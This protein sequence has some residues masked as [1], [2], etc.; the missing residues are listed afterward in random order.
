M[1]IIVIFPRAAHEAAHNN[2]GGPILQKIWRPG[3][4]VKQTQL[5]GPFHTLE[6]SYPARSKNPRDR[7]SKI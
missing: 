6:R 2:R 5:K 7:Q 3:I 4:Y 1:L